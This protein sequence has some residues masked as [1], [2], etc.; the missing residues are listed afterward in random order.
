[1]F[2]YSFL[3]CKR[4]S[5]LFHIN[6]LLLPGRKGASLFLLLFL[7]R[8]GLYNNSNKEVHKEKRAQDDQCNVSE[9]VERSI[10]LL[11]LH[12]LSNRVYGVKHK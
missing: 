5:H 12:V 8:E 6:P 11:R 4:V 3:G 7:L 10:I 1:M 9:G 2:Y